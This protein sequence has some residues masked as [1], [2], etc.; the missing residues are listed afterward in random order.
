MT[1]NQRKIIGLSGLAGSGK[2]TFSKIATEKFNFVELSFAAPLKNIVSQLFCWNRQRLDGN[3][4]DDRIWRETI[5]E[6]WSS[7]L[8]IA[9]FSP[10]RALQIFGTEVGR[11]I[12]DRLWI[13]I[14]RERINSQPLDKCIVISDC[15]FKNEL[16]LIKDMGG[17]TI[18]INRFT[19]ES[20]VGNSPQHASEQMQ[21]V[22]N[23]DFNLD[24]S[25]TLEDFER[26]ISDFLQDL[27]SE[28][29]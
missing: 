9:D 13:E 22:D 21:A 10:R 18:S 14:L 5:D 27:I 7:L 24:N 3:T 23:Y 11:Q 8:N 29:D 28:K 19:T 15:R 1:K 26:K 20:I 4:S 16:E 2:T 12:S 6:K 17:Q 25:G